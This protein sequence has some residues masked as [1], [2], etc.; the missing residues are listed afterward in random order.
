MI[1]SYRYGHLDN[2]KDFDYC[3]FDLDA[4]TKVTSVHKCDSASLS[5]MLVPVSGDALSCTVMLAGMRAGMEGRWAARLD[6]DLETREVQLVMQVCD[7]DKRRGDRRSG[8]G[9]GGRIRR[10]CYCYR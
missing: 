9:V 3:S 4:A 8:A 10:C 1:Y 7:G 5:A 6:T 2:A